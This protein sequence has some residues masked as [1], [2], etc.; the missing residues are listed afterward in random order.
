MGA[1]GRLIGA[2]ACG[3][4]ES[5]ESYAPDEIDALLEFAGGIAAAYDGLAYDRAERR[6]DDEIV[7]EL[8]ALRLAI[9]RR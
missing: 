4:R 7:E 2:I 6:R 3:A 9:E 5:G 1:R 8:R